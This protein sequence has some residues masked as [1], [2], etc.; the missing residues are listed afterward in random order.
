[1]LWS[2]VDGPARSGVVAVADGHGSNR[3]FRSGT[4]AD[5]A[6]QVALEIMSEPSP[7]PEG[8]EGLPR[9]V[10]QRWLTEVAAHLERSPFTYQEL[11][12]LQDVAGPEARFEVEAGP[13]LAYGTTLLAAAADDHGIVVLQ[14]GDGDILT[15]DGD[16]NVT[17]PLPP[18]PRSVGDATASLARPTAS[19]DARIRSLDVNDRGPVMILAATDGYANSF[20]EDAGFLQVGSDLLRMIES[21]G[22]ATVTAELD[23]WLKEVS[24]LGSGDDVTI[25]LLVAGRVLAD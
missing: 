14:V 3:C 7:D 25:G 10:V 12:H 19:G 11:A 4:G 13:S 5:L 23:G 22:L 17:R 20:E 6:V 2:P 1:V 16:G 8:A 18:D 24:E 21:E 9:R 15:V